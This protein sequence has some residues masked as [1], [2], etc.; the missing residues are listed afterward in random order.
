[1]GKL[2]CAFSLREEQS[3]GQRR[4]KRGAAGIADI[5]PNFVVSARIEAATSA[6]SSAR[7]NLRL[8]KQLPAE[9][10]RQSTVSAVF[11]A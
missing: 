9:R 3:R 11:R 2:L 6:Q 7:S 10:I 5:A 8:R 4:A 1:M